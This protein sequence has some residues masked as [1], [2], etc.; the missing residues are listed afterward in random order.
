MA[1][2]G[3]RVSRKRLRRRVRG[4]HH[5]S[6]YVQGVTRRD[7]LSSGPGNDAVETV[8][9]SFRADSEPPEDP[10]SPYVKQLPEEPFILFAG[11]L[12]RVKGVAEFVSAYAALP[13]APDLVL[14]G[15]IERDTPDELR[16][17]PDGARIV[18]DVPY[19][20]VLAAMDRSLFAVFPSLW[21]EPF[22]NVV[23]EA[24][25]R[26][27]AVIGTTPGGHEDMIIDGETGRLVPGGDVGAL[28]EAIRELLDDEAKRERFGAAG[29]ARA[30]RYT[31]AECVPQFEAHYSE[32]IER[33]GGAPAAAYADRDR[34]ER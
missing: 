19:D 34:V 21:P 1:T 6:S 18:R 31:A 7:F 29:L 5:I 13:D 25:S 10:A 9:P 23:H 27:L 22:G 12:R 14:L 33:A 4:V 15:T 24:M 16:K 32:V 26:G 8:I 17:L 20:A 11:A 2:V 30:R 3:L 28:T